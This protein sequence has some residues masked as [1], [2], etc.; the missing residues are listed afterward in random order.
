M[1]SKEKLALIKETWYDVDLTDEKYIDF[2]EEQ[3]FRDLEKDLEDLQTLKSFINNYLQFQLVPDDI[4][5]YEII[6]VK[7]YIGNS[8]CLLLTVDKLQ[9][10]LDICND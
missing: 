5:H 4:D 6:P 8:G 1:T 3:T 10:I 7:Q 9:K 2:D